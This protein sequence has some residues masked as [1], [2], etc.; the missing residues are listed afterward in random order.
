MAVSSAPVELQAGTAGTSTIY[1]NGT[2]ALVSLGND[3]IDYVDNN[4]SDVDNSTD[5]GTHSNFTA[6]QYGLDSINDTLT[7]ENNPANDTIWL[8]INA[9]DE[10]RTDWTRVGTNPYLD[11]IDYP[12]NNRQC[13]SSNLWS[14]A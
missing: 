14:A 10:T 5:V 6:Q 13:Y 8:Y 2:S 7:E 12:T 4:T 9:D 3:V 1:T 11:A